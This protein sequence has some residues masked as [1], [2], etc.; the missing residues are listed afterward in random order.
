MAKIIILSI[1]LMSIGAPIWYSGAANSR[2]A[3]R[4][5][6][7]VMLLFIVVWTYLCLRK[8]PALVPLK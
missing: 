1:V 7:T 3:L 8:Y 2:R 5:L 4:R 6:Q